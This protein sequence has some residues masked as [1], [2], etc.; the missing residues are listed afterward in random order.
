MKEDPMVLDPATESTVSVEMVP[1]PASTPHVGEAETVVD[2]L[3]FSL[4]NADLDAILAGLSLEELEEWLDEVDATHESL[5]A[6]MENCRRAAGRIKL[7]IDTRNKQLQAGRAFL[8]GLDPELRAQ[9]LREFGEK[10]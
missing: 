5:L 9:L 10:T 4:S 3:D 1:D 6:K 8:E 7:E 2:R